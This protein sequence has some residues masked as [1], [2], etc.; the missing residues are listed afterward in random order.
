[1]D[2]AEYAQYDG[3]GLAQLVRKR[4]V[5]TKELARLFLAAVEKVN[6]KI[7]AVI[8]TYSERVQTLD[9]SAVSNGPFAGRRS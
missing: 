7:N 1:M 6:P 4:K 2:L 3:L 9:D 5:T 8:E